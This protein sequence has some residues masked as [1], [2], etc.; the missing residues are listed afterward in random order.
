MKN[1][2]AKIRKLE[3]RIENLEGRANDTSVVSSGGGVYQCQS[4][5]CT[6]RPH[7]V[8]QSKY[9]NHN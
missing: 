3:E 8:Y 6:M 2:D 9:I 7:L 1:K 4:E 5:T